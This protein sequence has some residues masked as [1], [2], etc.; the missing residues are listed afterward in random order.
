MTGPTPRSER[1]SE[2]E[3]Y[4]EGEGSGQRV[5]W[6]YKRGDCKVVTAELGTGAIEN[7]LQLSTCIN[8]FLSSSFY[9]PRAASPL[10]FISFCL[11]LSSASGLS[12]SLLPACVHPAGCFSS[13]RAPSLSLSCSSC[14][15]PRHHR[16]TEQPPL[17]T[18]CA[19]DPAY[20]ASTKY[21]TAPLS[22]LLTGVSARN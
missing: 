19:N 17:T 15:R 2:S 18:Q 13:Q 12:S 9:L 16:L 4:R 3:R 11:S 7:R 1:G 20:L 10:V 5:G 21:L 14:M 8:Y 6:V 22:V